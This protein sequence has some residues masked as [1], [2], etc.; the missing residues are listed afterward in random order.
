MRIHAKFVECVFIVGILKRVEQQCGCEI[1]EL[2]IQRHLVFHCGIE[3]GMDGM[4]HRVSGQ[5]V[6]WTF[7]IIIIM[8]IN[9]IQCIGMSDVRVTEC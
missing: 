6:L 5:K 9:I 4:L 1:E 7:I 8:I 3:R 2:Q